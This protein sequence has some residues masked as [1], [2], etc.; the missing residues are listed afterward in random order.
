MNELEILSQE[1]EYLRAEINYY[2]EILFSDLSPAGCSIINALRAAVEIR[3]EN[4]RLRD[5]GELRRLEE[6]CKC[7][8][9][10]NAALRAALNP[11]T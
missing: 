9:D 7:L 5:S 4:R 6:Q 10:E 3:E 8:E 1:N 11:R 2:R